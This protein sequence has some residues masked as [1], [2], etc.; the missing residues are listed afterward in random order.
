MK[1]IPDINRYM[2]ESV[3]DPTEKSLL[4]LIREI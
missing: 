3:D 2:I 1:A 4:Y